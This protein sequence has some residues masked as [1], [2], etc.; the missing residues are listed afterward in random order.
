M[1]TKIAVSVAAVAVAVLTATPLHAQWYVGGSV[2]KSDI[3]FDNAAQSDQ[4]LD[5]GYTDPVTSS[6]T[7]DTGYRVF[8]GYQ[9][10]RYVAVEGAWVDLGKFGFR[11]DVMPR[12]SLSGAMT[13]SGFEVAA[14]GTLPL[15]DRFGLHARVGAFVAETKTSYSST[16]SI[17]L[18]LG[19]ETQKKRRTQLSYAAGASYNFNQNLALRAE[20]SRYS[21]LG[22]VLTGGE[23][24]AN[25]Y[26]LGIVYRF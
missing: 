3:K 19:G 24:D 17:E 16:G 10:H 14:V 1:N 23:T 2:G 8:G 18:L 4:F 20:W 6:S 21:K 22:S 9:L 7:R 5:L 15:N 13:I 26:S 12:G 11:T 25:L